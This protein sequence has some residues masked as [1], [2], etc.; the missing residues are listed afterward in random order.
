M[1]RW[2]SIHLWT[3]VLV[4]CYHS[5]TST[6][7]FHCKSFLSI[8]MLRQL[9]FI[10]VQGRQL[11]VRTY[12]E[13]RRTRLEYIISYKWRYS[14]LVSFRL[15]QLCKPTFMIISSYTLHHTTP[16]PI[17]AL[18]WLSFQFCPNT[19]VHLSKIKW[20]NGGEGREGI[21][22]CLAVFI[23]TQRSL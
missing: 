18:N 2:H 16:D 15:N 11:P 6:C 12:I 7:I 23:L 22:R 9:C 4:T 8:T 21:L 17:L 14:E 13:S 1:I 20:K 3:T 10:N 5:A 19:H